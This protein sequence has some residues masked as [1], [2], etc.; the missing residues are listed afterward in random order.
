M[1]TNYNNLT[2]FEACAIFIATI[3][4]VLIGFEIYITLPTH[5]KTAVSDAFGMFDMH[6]HVAKVTD[7][8]QFAYM[9]GEDFY[10]QF[11][12]AF[13]QVFSYPDQVGVPVLKFANSLDTYSQSVAYGYRVNNVDQESKTGQILGAFFDKDAAFESRDQAAARQTY[14]IYKQYYYH[15]PSVVK[16]LI[17]N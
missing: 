10:N 8:V 13:T 11:D 6:E 1:K 3:G 17:N 12:L 15:A 16:Q 5:Q 2:A 7:K 4:L 9:V 14:K